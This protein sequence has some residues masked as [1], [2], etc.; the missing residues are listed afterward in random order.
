MEKLLQ[1]GFL[2][3]PDLE[4]KDEELEDFLSFLKKLPETPLVVTKDHYEMFLKEK[5]EPVV[6]LKHHRE[7]EPKVEIKKRFLSVN[8]K[9]SIDDWVGYYKDRFR[10]L[11]EIL[12]KRESLAGSVS[13]SNL[14]NGEVK[15]IGMVREIMKLKR[16]M[17]LKV[18]DET[19]EVDV[20]VSS[21]TKLEGDIVL[22]EVIGIVGNFNGRM[23]YANEI[24]FPEVPMKEIKK[25]DEE[26]Y[27]CFTGDIHV[28]SIVFLKKEFENFLKWLRGEVG[29]AKQKELASKVKY[30]F[31]VGDL[32]DGVGVYPEQ[33]NELAIKDIYQQYELFAR[34]LKQIPED[35]I[36]IVIPGNHDA[37]RLDEPQPPPFKDFAAPI[38]DLDNVVVT[39]NPSLVNIHKKDGFPGFDVLLYHGYSMDY[40]VSEVDSLRKYGYNRADLV[41]AFMLKKRHLAVTHGSVRL[42]PN[43]RDFLV[44]ENVPDIFATGHIHKSK[45]GW[46]KNILTLSASCFQGQTTF[47]ERLG[48]E[49]EPGRIPI[50][51]LKDM[52]VK[53]LKF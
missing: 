27:A 36:V 22:D 44:I 48:H 20:L 25:G 17:I 50:V 13:I 7:V 35:K 8:K 19:G 6:I 53:V 23:L 37:T 18:E 10:K 11:R 51:N 2:P 24:I 15:T 52:S 38:Y 40:F 3:A 41:M 16:A 5:S 1:A 45:V 4:V 43:P 42:A 21:R 47:Q 12:S 33:E 32:V 49:P 28:G 29:D 14:R 34:Y 26:V 31:F 46:Y 30:V 39:S 9:F